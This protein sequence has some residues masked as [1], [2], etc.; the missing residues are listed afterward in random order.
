MWID[1]NIVRRSAGWSV[2]RIPVGQALR[3]LPTA[4]YNQDQPEDRYTGRHKFSVHI[5]PPGF[6]TEEGR[7]QEKGQEIKS[8]DYVMRPVESGAS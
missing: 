3:T 8:A 7:C 4:V 2:L 5:A 6:H 1:P